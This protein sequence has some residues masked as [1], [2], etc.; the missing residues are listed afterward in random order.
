MGHHPREGGDPEGMMTSLDP[1]LRGDDIK[2]PVIAR[3]AEVRVV[4]RE[5]G[6]LVMVSGWF[7]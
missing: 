5:R 7:Q 3:S 1:R 4:V 6:L 2:R